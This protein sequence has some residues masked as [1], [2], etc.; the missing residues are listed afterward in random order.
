MTASSTFSPFLP[1]A[2]GFLAPVRVDPLIRV[3]SG[4]D[5]G[6]V[7]PQKV[8]DCSD[9]LV[10]L[11]VNDD[12]SFDR[13]FAARA[14]LKGLH[15][16]DHTVSRGGFRRRFWRCL[17][18]SL[19]GRRRW[20]DVAQDW[21]LWQDYKRFFSGP[22]RHFRQRVHHWAQHSNDVSLATILSR[23]ES[24]RIFVK[25]DIEGGEYGLIDTLLEQNHRIT[26]LAMEWHFA[27]VMRLSFNDAIQRLQRDYVLVH[28]HGNNHGTRAS[29]GLP[30]SLEISFLHRSLVDASSMQ[31]RLELPL[32]GLDATNR[33]GAEDYPLRFRAA[34]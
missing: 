26:G 30:E 2:L 3:G 4:G 18:K 12:W 11:G 16:Y 29:D 6:Y 8:L 32:A 23:V 22:H 27:D 9:F 13:D 20:A 28:L 7:L 19:T 10:S 33:A 5:G 24:D 1:D 17:F 25:I 34:A 21:A 14:R 31:R 15:A